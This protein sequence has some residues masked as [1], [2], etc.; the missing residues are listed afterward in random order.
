M[1]EK[2]SMHAQGG[3]VNQLASTAT[4][5]PTEFDLFFQLVGSK[6]DRLSDIIADF[7]RFT[8]RMDAIANRLDP[9]S[10][11]KNMPVAC[12]TDNG[13]NLKANKPPYNQPGGIAGQLI[14]NVE[15]W[16][17]L[18]ETFTNRV[19]PNIDEAIKHIEKHI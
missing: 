4:K 1:N 11:S 13:E 12:A 14:K 8:D 15:H 2:P 19:L 16:N 10:Y 5:Q 3:S 6:Q 17:G 18:L 7:Y 9:E